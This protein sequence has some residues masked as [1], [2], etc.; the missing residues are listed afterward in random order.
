MSNLKVRFSL[1]GG[2]VEYPHIY[3]KDIYSTMEEANI[4]VNYILEDI[5]RKNARNV[6]HTGMQMVDSI[7]E[8]GTVVIGRLDGTFDGEEF[9]IEIIEL[10]L[11]IA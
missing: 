6:K 9:Y 4:S 11:S 3:G 1:H 7:Y 10:E 5:I 8:D 2:E